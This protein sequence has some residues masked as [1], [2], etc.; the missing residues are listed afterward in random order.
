MRRASRFSR[1]RL[2]LTR[3]DAV[4]GLAFHFP[5]IHRM[6]ALDSAKVQ[7]WAAALRFWTI[8]DEWNCLS[9]SI[10]YH[11]FP[12]AP[13]VAVNEVKQGASRRFGRDSFETRSTS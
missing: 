4:R 8:V 1:P 12:P 13:Y 5:A 7:P 11:L 10:W 6:V 2:S 3:K 9:H